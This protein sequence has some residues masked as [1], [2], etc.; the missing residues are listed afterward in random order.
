MGETLDPMLKRTWAAGT[1][2]Y[3]CSRRRSS[4]LTLPTPVR[5]RRPVASWRESWATAAVLWDQMLCVVKTRNIAVQ[6]TQPVMSPGEPALQINI[7]IDQNKQR[8]FP[9]LPLYWDVTGMV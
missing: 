4:A 1:I 6:Q 5:S 9:N 2:C 8:R 7:N 3:Q